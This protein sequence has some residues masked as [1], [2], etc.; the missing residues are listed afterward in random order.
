MGSPVFVTT[1][2]KAKQNRQTQDNYGQKSSALGTP[3]YRGHLLN[4]GTRILFCEGRYQNF[5]KF[6]D[7]LQLAKEMQFHS[8]FTI[9]L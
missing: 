4:F 9:L 7:Q 6:K 2:A 1:H 8:S 5:L 3:R